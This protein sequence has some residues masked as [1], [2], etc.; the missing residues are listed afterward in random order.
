MSSR[1]RR[2]TSTTQKKVP[3]EEA[4]TLEGTLE[5]GVNKQVSN[6]NGRRDRDAGDSVRVA[7]ARP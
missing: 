6:R 4:P 7:Q 5:S 1:G 2:V 3:S